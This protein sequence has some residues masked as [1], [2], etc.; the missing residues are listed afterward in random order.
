MKIGS[1]CFLIRCDLARSMREICT[2]LE[3]KEGDVYPYIVAPKSRPDYKIQAR[4][5]Q[6]RKPKQGEVQQGRRLYD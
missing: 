4:L 1:N 6:V 2:V 3:F 5:E